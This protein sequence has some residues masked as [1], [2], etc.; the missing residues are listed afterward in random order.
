[1]PTH[2]HIDRFNLDEE[3]NRL[4]EAKRK[5]LFVIP[6]L[7]ENVGNKY[8]RIVKYAIIFEEEK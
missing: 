5:I 3:I 2:H 4:K 1:M 8:S 6:E 7:I